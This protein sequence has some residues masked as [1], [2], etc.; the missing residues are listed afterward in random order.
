MNDGLA[1]R[2]PCTCRHSTLALEV[3]IPSRRT[4]QGRGTHQFMG[5]DQTEAFSL[6]NYHDAA[7]SCQEH[8]TLRTTVA[9]PSAARIE[10]NCRGPLRFGV[11]RLLRVGKRSEK[12]ST[13]SKLAALE[14]VS[15]GPIS[16][17]FG[18]RAQKCRDSVFG[19][20]GALARGLSTR[21]L[22]YDAGRHWL[23]NNLGDVNG[24]RSGLAKGWSGSVDRRSR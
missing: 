18:D 24:F 20:R 8:C 10:S 7:S 17:A 23:R 21:R 11:G 9:S 19:A 4:A 5:I 15:G 13:P 2:L 14:N 6:V 12:I 16:G 1:V 22:R 3:I